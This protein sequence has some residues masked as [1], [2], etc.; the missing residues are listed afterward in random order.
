MY[1]FQTDAEHDIPS[2]WPPELAAQ[3]RPVVHVYEVSDGE[4]PPKSRRRQSHEDGANPAFGAALGRLILGEEVEVDEAL[5]EARRAVGSMPQM[6]E[7]SEPSLNLT[8]EVSRIRLAAVDDYREILGLSQEGDL[9]L[10]AVQSKYRQIMR[11]L[12]PDKRDASMG[13]ASQ[14]ACDE[15]MERVQQALQGL[16]KEIE[17]GPDPSFVARQGM[18]RMQE[19]QRLRA[20]QARQKQQE[21]QM[22]ALIQDLDQARSAGEATSSPKEDDATSQI[23]RLL[24]QLNGQ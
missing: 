15:A 7:E 23:L 2:H 5:E 21:H 4:E 6:P 8:S 12:H 18:R 19:L 3:K 20:Q 11:L 22:G 13:A 14:T 24:S 9:E 1:S 17:V 10:S 16:K